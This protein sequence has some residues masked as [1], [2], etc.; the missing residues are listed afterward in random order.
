[1]SFVTH[2]CHSWL[3]CV[4]RDTLRMCLNT[5]QHVLSW[6]HVMWGFL[7]NRLSLILVIRGLF[8]WFVTRPRRSWV[9]SSDAINQSS[10]WQP[11]SA[12]TCRRTTPLSTALHF[13][14]CDATQQSIKVQSFSA[15]LSFRLSRSSSR[16]DLKERTTRTVPCQATWN[17]SSLWNLCSVHI[18]DAHRCA[19]PSA[20]YHIF[21]VISPWVSTV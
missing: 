5:S 7:M 6:S 1:M 13:P 3:I 2:S 20:H 11:W 19:Y 10:H 8:M 21:L 4:I 14:H 18:L 17:L 9:I 12:A 16:S 15:D